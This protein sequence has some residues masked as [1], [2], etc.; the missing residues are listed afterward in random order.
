MTTAIL[1][2]VATLSLLVA[3]PA[4]MATEVEQK[5]KQSLKLASEQKKMQSEKSTTQSVN[6]GTN[7]VRNE[8]GVIDEDAQIE[9]ITV[10]NGNV[11]IDGVKVPRGVRKFHSEKTGKNYRIDWGKGDNVSVTEQ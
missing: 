4:L 5:Q 9:G 2:C 7:E 6:V 8:S 11:S 3:T 1:K 10:I